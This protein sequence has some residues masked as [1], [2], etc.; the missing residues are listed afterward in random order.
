MQDEVDLF[1]HLTLAKNR[2][3]GHLFLDNF[4][5]LRR[6]YCHPNPDP[7]HK[8]DAFHPHQDSSIHTGVKIIF[9]VG[10]GWI[11]NLFIKSQIRCYIQIR[12]QLR[13]FY[14]IVFLKCLIKKCIQG[15]VV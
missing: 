8:G 12:N 2:E 3:P 4:M 14:D 9:Y 6:V 13:F 7:P 11:N 5:F 10:T 1:L 15:I